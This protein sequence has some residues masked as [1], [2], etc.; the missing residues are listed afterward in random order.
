MTKNKYKLIYESLK[1]MLESKDSSWPH[2]YTSKETSD[3]MKGASHKD[4][5]EIEKEIK[6]K[7]PK[8]HIDYLMKRD[9]G[10]CNKK[11]FIIFSVGEGL[12]DNEG[13]KIKVIEPKLISIGRDIVN[14]YVYQEKDLHAHPNSPAPVYVMW[15]DS[16]NLEKVSESFEEFV[17]FIYTKNFDDVPEAEDVEGIWKIIDKQV[18]P[19][20]LES[21]KLNSLQKMQ[22]VQES[23]KVI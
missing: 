15:K 21:K 11:H 10:F 8:D 19:I 4:I 5:T 13:E 9:G 17:K 1:Y 20:K 6:F 22:M 3:K 7:L 2:D 23:L 14:V 18:K 12:G 16:S